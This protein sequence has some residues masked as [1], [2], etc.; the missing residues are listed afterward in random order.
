VIRRGRLFE[1][2]PPKRS[3]TPHPSCRLTARHPPAAGTWHRRLPLPALLAVA[4]GVVACSTPNV[5]YDPTKPHHRPDGFVNLGDPKPEA[6]GG[7]WRWQW[8]RWQADLPPDRPERVPRVATDLAALREHASRGDATVTWVGHATVLWQ[9]AGLNLLTDPHFGPRAS[10]V[11][12]AGP[13]RK[14]PLPF[15]LSELPRIDVVL[16]SHNHYD[17]LDRGTVKALAA[18]PGGPPLFIVPLGVD[19]WMADEGI[20]SVKAM[21]WWDRHTLPTPRGPVTVH[22]VPAHH[23]SS[24]TPWDRRATLWGGFVLQAQAGSA[25]VSL[26]FAGDTGHSPLFADLGRRFGGFDHALIPVGC[27]EPRWFMGRQHVNEEEAVQIHRDVR[28]RFSVG[29]HWGSFRL[30][31]DPIHAPVEGLP[32]ALARQGE[33]PE[34]FVLMGL[35]Q[36]R[37]VKAAAP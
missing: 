31:D 13:D 25:P 36:T 11:G 34:A 24:R 17:H 35:G 18:Q 23:W 27:Y 22:F 15:Q 16:L 37:V 5:H 9:V 10:P 14:T 12:F 19:R 8:E 30:C 1:P 29:V 3:L 26:Y 20:T 33:A 4:L 28:S 6:E 21:D 2:V 7:F 32:V